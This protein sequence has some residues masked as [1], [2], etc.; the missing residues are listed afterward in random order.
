M[1]EAITKHKRDDP[2][3]YMDDAEANIVTKELKVREGRTATDIEW[4]EV[5][6]LEYS[7]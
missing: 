4:D 1:K 6:D 7:E 2:S 5:L 3:R